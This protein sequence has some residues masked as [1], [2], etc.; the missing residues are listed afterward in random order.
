[1]ERLS[2]WFIHALENAS[3]MAEGAAILRQAGDRIGMPRPAAT[4]DVDEQEPPLHRGKPLAVLLGWPEEWVTDFRA[5]GLNRYD[6]FSNHCR[7]ENRPFTWRASENGTIWN[8][9]VLNGMPRHSM[10]ALASQ[11]NAGITIPV[12]RAGG[13]IGHVTFGHPDPDANI[14]EIHK[15]FGRDLF[16]IAHQ[17]VDALDNWGERKKTG[18]DFDPLTPR[19]RECLRWVSMG[20][21]DEQVSEILFRSPATTRF[22]IKNAMRKLGAANRAHAISLAYQRRILTAHI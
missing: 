6:P 2:D 19:E 17:F 11:I 7:Y 8:G 21:T 14:D 9:H 18:R 3:S 5:T 4:R 20:N 22:H 1:M 12:F 10:V 16:L 13:R 15:E